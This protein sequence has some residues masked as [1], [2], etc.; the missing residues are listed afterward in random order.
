MSEFLELI[1]EGFRLAAN[2]GQ[3]GADVA[4][5]SVLGYFKQVRVW[6]IRFAITA[7]AP[8]VVIIP[9]LFFKLALGGLYGGY[10]VWVVLLVAAE[11][12]LLT[13]MYL[14]WR[15]LNAVFPK[16][17]LELQEWLDFI[18][19]VVFNGLSLGIF[20][21]LFPIWRSPGAFPLLLLVLACWVTLPMSGISDLFKQIYPGVR[22]IQLVVLFGVLV[23]KMA[24]PVQTQQLGWATGQAVEDALLRPV[25]QREITAEWK[26]ITWFT[27]AGGVRVW[28]SGS[29]AEGYRLWAAPGFDQQSGEELRPVSDQKTREVILSYLAGRDRLANADRALQAEENRRREEAAR[30]L[31]VEEQRRQDDAARALAAAQR[32]A[33]LNAQ[34]RTAERAAAQRRAGYLYARNLPRSVDFIVCAATATRQTMD[35]FADALVK[36]LRGK[37]KT[38]SSIVFSPAFVTDGAF[39]AFFGGRGGADLRNMQVST[40][41]SRLILARISI[42]SV[43]QGTTVA[44]LVSASVGVAFSVLSANDG[45][46]VDGFS[47]NAVG[48]G[49]SEAGAISA[50][51]DRV[52]DQLSQHGY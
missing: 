45:S 7:A 14:V 4:R 27:N 12:L 23:M 50:A 17:A 19:S 18:K 24:F 34:E 36:Y 3:A 31:V 30:A 38:A 47:V 29:G 46:V 28:Y 8:L 11:L 9:C 37:G 51:L 1:K 2:L 10:V 39:D 48:A 22:A 35:T 26:D 13:P 40:M 16:M 33:D 21:T 43:K 49:T 20:V 41:G 32:V 5:A 52:L 6:T 44:G 42:K 25:G 15:R